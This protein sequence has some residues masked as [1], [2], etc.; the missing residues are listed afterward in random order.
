MYEHY[1]KIVYQMSG[2]HKRET[3]HKR[4]SIFFKA[5]Y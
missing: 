4:R 1:A 5:T 2:P 3:C